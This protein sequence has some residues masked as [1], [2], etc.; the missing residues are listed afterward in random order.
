MDYIIA[1]YT[2]D[3]SA[4]IEANETCLIR[5]VSMA[6]SYG[7]VDILRTAFNDILS[8]YFRD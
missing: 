2:G 8:K 4:R 5:Y 1:W 7:R 6:T 3:D